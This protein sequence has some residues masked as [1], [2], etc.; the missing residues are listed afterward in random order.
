MNGSSFM[1]DTLINDIYTVPAL[2]DNGCECYA[3]VSDFMIR[4]AKLP[5]I[6]LPRRKLTE[7]T[8]SDNGQKYF[9]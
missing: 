7:A 9:I 3:A 6:K 4:K 5:R 2:I 1:I 8:S